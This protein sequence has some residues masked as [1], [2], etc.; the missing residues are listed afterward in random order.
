MAS[1]MIKFGPYVAA[2]V[3]CVAC[4]ICTGTGYGWGKD[5]M[6]K[7]TDSTK[8]ANEKN[9]TIAFCVIMMVFLLIAWG[10]KKLL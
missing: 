3:A 4:M 10:M 2:L 7:S 9:S 6:N 5:V 1:F 8:I